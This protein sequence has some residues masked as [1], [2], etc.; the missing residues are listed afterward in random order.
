M[1]TS[2][3]AI[4]AALVGTAIFGSGGWRNAVVL[5]VFFVSSSVL[6]QLG[7]GSAAKRSLLRIGKSGARDGAQVL[8][9][10]GI[11]AVCALAAMTG[12]PLWQVAFVGAV[13]AATSDTWGTEVGT[14]QEKQPRSILTRKAN[15]AR[16]L[17]RRFTSR[18]AG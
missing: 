16:Y 6:S 3:G 1:L 14:L 11:A 13:A 17:G 12:N 7:R 5:L 8:A 18:F 4:A 10:G 15:R 9:N 2:S